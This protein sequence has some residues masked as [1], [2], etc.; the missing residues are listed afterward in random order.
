MHPL[1]RP[2]TLTCQH[3]LP[4]QLPQ[5]L[6]L[7]VS[8]MRLPF[9]MFGL[10]S[11][12]GRRCTHLSKLWRKKD[13]SI[14]L[15]LLLL[16]RQD[17]LTMLHPRQTLVP[18]AV[19]TAATRAPLLQSPATVISLTTPSSVPT[20]RRCTHAALC[21]SIL[22]TSTHTRHALIAPF[23]CPVV[24]TRITCRP[25]APSALACV[26]FAARPTSPTPSS[27]SMC[28]HAVTGLPN[29]T[30]AANGCDGVCFWSTFR[31]ARGNLLPHPLAVVLRVGIIISTT[32]SSTPSMRTMML[33]CCAVSVP[34]A[35]P[36]RRACNARS[37]TSASMALAVP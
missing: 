14:K 9:G 34:V 12:P 24:Y 35:T 7:A 26:T 16:L 33:I 37:I 25:P 19:H 21:R 27:R 36:P 11:T 5:L 29:A 22:L 28:D 3:P 18:L 2:R 17:L 15:L 6:P 30:H 1:L 20:V 4:P 32:T 23:N 13:C 10:C 31:L 8:Q